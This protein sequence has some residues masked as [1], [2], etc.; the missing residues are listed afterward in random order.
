MTRFL[1]ALA[2]AAA[3]SA[4]AAPE[5]AIDYR[6][7]PPRDGTSGW[8]RVELGFDAG[9]RSETRLRV[10][11]D[12][13]G[14]ADFYRA[15]RDVHV[16][17]VSGAARVPGEP[18][19]WV[20]RHAPT[21]RVHARYFILNDL[22]E[23]EEGAI[24]HRDFYRN[25]IGRA[26]AHFF[27]HGTLLLPEALPESAAVE[28]CFD[29]EALPAEWSFASSHGQV[30][31]R[32]RAKLAP[33]AIRSTVFVAGDF[34]LHRREI[35]GRPMWVAI[36][37]RWKFDDARFVDAA[38]RVVA[39]HRA[40]W[41][42]FDF[43]SYLLTLGPNRQPSGS[44]GGTGLHDSFAMHAS[45]DFEVPGPAF[46]HIVAHEHLHTWVPRRL[47]TMGAEES[48]RYWFSEGFTNYLTHRLLLR[49]GL[50]S[51]E[52]Y[53]RRIN[54]V[55]DEYWLATGRD[56]TNEQVAA[57]FWIDGPAQKVPYARGEVVALLWSRRLA[58]RGGSLEAVLRSLRLP[59]ANLPRETDARPEDLAVNRL[60]TALA[61]ELGPVADRDIARHV[62]AGEPVDA[63]ADFLGPCFTGE[64][65]PRA[66][67][68][69]GFD[70]ASLKTRV[71]SGLVAGSAA[72]RAGLRNGMD[73]RGWSIEADASRETEIRVL[74]E[75][76]LRSI[77]YLPASAGRVPVPQYRVKPQA[78]SEPACRAWL[79][80][81]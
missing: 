29:F 74:E 19:V 33:P 25:M 2:L 35:D 60:R 17:G 37:G 68:E 45:D 65:V 21:G 20:V 14:V 54:A 4:A 46:D 12:W 36:R 58:E 22:R 8:L 70:A 10:A 75:G 77:R 44:T 48:R 1:A 67:F 28:A 64:R 53:A 52:D 7:E 66:R 81:T 23:T 5:C 39:S 59:A 40:F 13:G 72:E 49:S 80:A 15:V 41:S 56:L 30:S 6:F 24:D 42:D 18:N 47:G 27:G 79:A 34:R 62:E 71:L 51:L 76:K 3:G 43:P 57:R 73:L 55:L 32:F 26:H 31:R 78:A 63:D 9:G 38:A 69:L 16:P 61:R 11:P 50:W